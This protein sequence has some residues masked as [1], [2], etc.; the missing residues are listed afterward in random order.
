MNEPNY[1]DILEVAKLLNEAE[2]PIDRRTMY[3]YQISW[4]RHPIK[5]YKQKRYYSHILQTTDEALQPKKEG[6]DD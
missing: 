3:F 5:R 6:S 2:V 4:W 1:E